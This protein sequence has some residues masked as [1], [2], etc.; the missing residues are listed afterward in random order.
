MQAIALAAD[1]DEMSVV[2]EPVEERGDRR[3]VAEHLGPVIQRP[4]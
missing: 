2:H 3:C 4:I 1:L